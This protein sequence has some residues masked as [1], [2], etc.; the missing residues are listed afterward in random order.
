MQTHNRAGIHKAVFILF[1]LSFLFL[2]PALHAAGPDLIGGQLTCLQGTWTLAT[3]FNS[4]IFAIIGLTVALVA[5][6]HMLGTAYS[7]PEWTVWARNEGITLVWSLA[8][9]GVILAAFGASCTLSNL[10]LGGTTSV[11]SAGAQ[12]GGLYAAPSQ[13]ANLTPA[14]RASLYM[15]TLLNDYGVSVASQLVRSSVRDQMSSLN[16]AYWSIPVFD[17]GGIAYSA[18]QRAWATDKDLVAD[19]YLPLM[20]SITAQKL[21]MDIAVPGVFSILLP[22]AIMLRMFFLTRDVGN[23]LLALSF[24]LYFALPLTYV[25]F[26]DA[27]ASVQQSIFVGSNPNQPFGNQFSLGYDPIIGDAMQRVGFMATQA[28]I[29]PNLALVVLVSM[30]MALH[31]AFRGMVA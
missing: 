15:G 12:A 11:G 7:K 13:N 9:V 30:T 23:L 5:A 20:I 22:A 10:M 3:D 27:T 14:A 28:I 19:I 26:F 21:L 4:P 31:K 25:F 16:Y 24:A 8:L 17:G 6:A 29:A 18:N 2:L 1:F